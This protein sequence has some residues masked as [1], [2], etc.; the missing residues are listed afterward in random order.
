M[1]PR[2]VGRDLDVA[3]E[4]TPN[5]RTRFVAT[6]GTSFER[7][8]ETFQ[9]FCHF[10]RAPTNS[11]CVLWLSWNTPSDQIRDWNRDL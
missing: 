9:G 3:R 5:F 10:S 2:W 4:S 7:V 6:F 1:V 11:T 8:V